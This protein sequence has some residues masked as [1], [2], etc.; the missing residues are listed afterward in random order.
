[1]DLQNFMDAEYCIDKYFEKH[2]KERLDFYIDSRNA[3]LV[4]GRSTGFGIT[5]ALAPSEDYATNV[6]LNFPAKDIEKLG[7]ELQRDKGM[8][9][10]IEVLTQAWRKAAVAQVGEARYQELSQK[11]GGDLATAYVGHRLMMKMVDYEVEKNPVR[12]SADFIL[13]E[14]H[15]SSLL[16]LGDAPTSEL[17]Q[18]IDKR[19]IERYDPSLLERGTGKVL[20]SLTDLT[21][22]APAFGVS[23]WAGLTKFVAV[24]LGLGLVGDAV[25]SRMNQ[26]PDV[27]Q[28]VSAALFGSK[29]DVLAQLRSQSSSVNPY[30]SEVVKA[31]D[32]QLGKKIVRHSNSLFAA[33]D[34]KPKFGL[35]V[36]KLPE[37][38]DYAEQLRREG[39]MHFAIREHF[40]NR[41]NKEEAPQNRNIYQNGQTVSQTIPTQSLPQNQTSGN[42]P[43]SGW[44]G[45]FDTLGLN[46]FSD[47]GK[48]LG[49]VLA[50][51]PDMLVG[52]FTG[53][54]RNLKFGDNMMP[55]AAIFAGM[56]VKNPLLKM[57]LV[58]LGGANLL[59]KAGHEALENRDG[60]KP[61]PVRQYRKYDDEVLDLR[62]SQPV[63]KGNTLV[64]TIDNVPS[65]ITI[66]DDAVDAYY[67][68]VLPL[69]TLANA[70]LR[71]Y[72]EQQ[73]ILQENYDRQIKVDERQVQSMGIK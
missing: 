5:N 50:M 60:V 39:E 23:S 63:M 41:G 54:S 51:L 1:M 59:N 70:V 16:S 26:Q 8:S 34:F 45:M 62:I 69:N 14:A 67:Q 52:M 42:V 35:E 36:A 31:V 66:N 73:R 71:K 46:G 20:G 58:G 24:D 7:A 30:S 61:Q 21:L 12:G 68:G 29:D 56:F 9:H 43:I 2:L 27:S 37:I 4:A 44:G 49:Y 38:P 64:A 22:T 19:I 47:V 17:Q 55:I 57:L 48:N 40:E 6:T 13:S 15:R 18:Y 10:D 28:M 65:V 72:D 3:A 11:L 25:S 32:G 33:G 53:K